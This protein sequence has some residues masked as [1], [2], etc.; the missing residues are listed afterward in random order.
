MS[1]PTAS[2]GNTDK[3][4]KFLFYMQPLDY[5]IH[6]LAKLL[7]SLRRFRN[8]IT[9]TTESAIQ[10]CYHL[11]YALFCLLNIGEATSIDSKIY[12]SK[13]RCSNQLSQA[14]KSLNRILK[15]AQVQT[16]QST[17]ASSHDITSDTILAYTNSTKNRT[18]KSTSESLTTL[19]PNNGSLSLGASYTVTQF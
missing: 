9:N 13:E 10:S 18:S 6:L 19:R 12:A 2:S 14:W 5:V 1:S 7:Y 17:S 16:R 8:T 4:A 11:T 15:R 3:S